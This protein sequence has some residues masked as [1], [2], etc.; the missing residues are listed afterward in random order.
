MSEIITVN[1]EKCVGCN[2]CIRSCPAPE[3]NITKMLDDGRFVTTVNSERCIAC[4]ECVR[5]CLHGARDYID[6]TAEVM[7]AINKKERLIILATPSIKTVFPQKWKNILNWFRKQGCMVFDVSFGAD[8]CTW[9]HIR[10]IQNGVVENIITQ[11]CAA[12]VKYIETYQPSI[13]K[14]LS[15]IQS[16][17]LC[18]AIYIKR[19][20]RLTNRIAV[21]SPCVAK[22]NEFTETMFVDFNVTFQKMMEYFNEND[23]RILIDNNDDLAYNFDG[24]QGQMGA[25]YPK[26]GGLRDNLLL[27]DPDIDI[28]NSEGVHKV[29][30]EL[31]MYAKLTESNKPKVF[32][33]LSCEFGCN[34]GAGASSQRSLFE[35]MQ[36][37]NNVEKEASGRRKIKGGFFRASEDKILKRF[38]EELMLEDFVRKYRQFEP[39]YEPTLEELEPVFHSIGK[40]TEADKN[41]NCHACGYSS[42]KAMATAIYR[43]INVPENCILH[44]KSVLRSQQSSIIKQNEKIDKLSADV[45]DIARSINEITEATNATDNRKNDVHDLLNNVIEFCNSTQTMDKDGLTS[46]VEILENA[47]AAF[48]DLNDNVKNTTENTEA[49][50]QTI[51][52]IRLIVT[53]INAVLQGAETN[54][55]S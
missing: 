50:N 43:G 52:D 46:L 49:V 36:T 5:S 38:D 14:N 26:P 30:P 44:A 53:D 45:E 6:D 20:L 27:H 12:I 31:D 40:Y 10:A 42:C 8:I 7:D 41:F 55:E 23:I 29:Y 51:S 39:S 21:L 19:Y 1:S 37:M 34:V 54:K 15:P 28:V 48:D 32:D 17:I 3:A 24:E 25:I 33:V 13:L 2:A 9:A 22:K 35:I 4:G 47:D 16:P 18:T 11:P